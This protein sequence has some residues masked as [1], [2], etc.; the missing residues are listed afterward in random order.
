MIN[1]ELK[2]M[3]FKCYLQMLSMK[4]RNWSG[5]RDLEPEKGKTFT[6]FKMKWAAYLWL[7]HEWN[8][9]L[10]LAEVSSILVIFS[11]LQHLE[12]DKSSCIKC[13]RQ[14]TVIAYDCMSSKKIKT[15][16]SFEIQMESNFPKELKF[17]FWLMDY[18]Y[19]INRSIKN[20]SKW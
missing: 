13:C 12:L 1:S 7:L 14:Y 4:K 19:I 10:D 6:T 5:D 9:L 20:N 11:S 17:T 15:T 16:A 3:V 8:F 2:R 18:W